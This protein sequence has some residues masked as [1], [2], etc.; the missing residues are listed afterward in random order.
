L[1]AAVISFSDEVKVRQDFT[2]NPDLA[3]HALRMLRQE[4]GASSS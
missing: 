4:G 1:L 2:G 3:I